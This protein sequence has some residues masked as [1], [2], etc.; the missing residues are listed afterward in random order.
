MKIVLHLGQGKTGT[1]ALQASLSAAAG[2]LRARKVLYP[3]FGHRY[4]AHHLLVALCGDPNCMPRWEV[5]KLG[6]PEGTRAAARSAW[7]TMLEDIR[8][9]PPE[10]LVLSSE[11]LLEMLDTDGKRHLAGLLSDLSSDITPVMYVRNPVEHFRSRLQ[12]SLKNSDLRRLPG[13]GRLI[14]SVR[15]AETAFGRQLEFVAYDR[16]LLHGGDVVQDFAVRFMAPW[17][18]A[19]EI[20]TRT[21]NES[22]SAE[23]LVLMVELRAMAGG[24]YEASRRVAT[25]VPELQA[26][27]R[28]DPAARP[29]TLLPE[30]AEAALRSATFN[31]WLAE[32][33]RL[34]LPGLDYAKI[35]N[36]EIPA[37]I[38]E[39]PAH[40]LFRHDPDR[41]ARL[42]MA[43]GPDP[44]HKSKDKRSVKPSEKP[45]P[46]F[47][48]ML[49]RFLLRKLAS[50]QDRNT[51]AVPSRASPSRRSS[52]GDRD[53]D[54]SIDGNLDSG[55]R[56]RP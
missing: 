6:G 15:N 31:L 33:G 46:R 16:A 48:D 52:Q 19:S 23:A 29:P 12:Q 13:N 14:D 5:D 43:I 11:Y 27:D 17:V 38:S 34:H 39:A 20:P 45:K 8:R 30:V 10:L 53:E 7:K 42:R 2:H 37:W 54:N 55:P 35:D 3:D 1:T 44:F 36:A 32:N 28:N 26:L 18:E 40:A 24:T 51:G 9:D 21:A 49:L 22:L 50:S 25:L 56:N 41:L 4:I 47:Q